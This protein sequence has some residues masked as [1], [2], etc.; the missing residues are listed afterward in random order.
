MRISDWSSDVCS[1]DLS[2]LIFGL[3]YVAG[4]GCTAVVFGPRHVGSGLSEFGGARQPVQAE[5][6]PRGVV[7]AI[8]PADEIGIAAVGQVLR[9]V[10]AGV[11]QIGRA[12][13]RE[14]GGQYV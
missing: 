13:C 11:A 3:R 4:A 10:I 5:D 2:V 14:R 1:S 8:G 9:G 7:Q 12:S 6:S